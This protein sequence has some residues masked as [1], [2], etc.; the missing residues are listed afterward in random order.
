MKLDQA[1]SRVFI[2]LSILILAY[3]LYLGVVWLWEWYV[4]MDGY[5]SAWWPII[6][7]FLWRNMSI[8]VAIYALIC[9]QASG[10]AELKFNKIFLKAFGLSLILT[11][12]GMM[13]V[14]GHRK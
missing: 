11:P 13:I 5:S 9:L 10:L 8:V 12:P 14:Y 4:S 2:V 1:V 6:G 3:W 7:S